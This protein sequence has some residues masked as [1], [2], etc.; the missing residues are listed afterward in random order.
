MSIAI[1]QTMV[2]AAYA[3]GKLHEEEKNL[4]RTYQALY[5]P[6]QDIPKQELDKEM[7]N[8]AKKKELKVKDRHIIEDIGEKMSKSEKETAFALAAEVCYSNFNIVPTENN[9]LDFLQV[10]WDIKKNTANAVYKS[11]KLRYP[12][13]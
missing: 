12:S 5:P 6:L 2:L 3:D 8:I 13:R 11:L 7:M 1:L 9:L 4:I 10:N